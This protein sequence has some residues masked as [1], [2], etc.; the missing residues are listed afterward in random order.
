MFKLNYDEPNN[1]LTIYLD[2]TISSKDLIES[3]VHKV[4][5]AV[6]EFDTNKDMNK[7]FDA[8]KLL[9][10]DIDQNSVRHFTRV[11]NEYNKEYKN[12]KIAVVATTDLMFGNL[13]VHEVYS[14][15][16]GLERATFREIEKAKEWLLT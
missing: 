6:D 7:L 11:T 2:I 4:H 14:D 5:K 1:V 12:I 13:R 15:E 9:V 8:R 10:P 16:A 3:F